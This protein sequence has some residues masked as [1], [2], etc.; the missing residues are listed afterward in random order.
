MLETS[1]IKH[2]YTAIGAAAHEDVDT[3][4]AESDIKN[5]FVV[6]YELCLCRKGRYVPYCAGSVDARCDDET[7]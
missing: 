5:L 6:R 7:R 3:A 4:R 2:S 1:K